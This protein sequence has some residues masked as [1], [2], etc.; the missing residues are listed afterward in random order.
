MMKVSAEGRLIYMLDENS[1]EA[2]LLNV[3]IVSSDDL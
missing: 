3:N 1:E 2:L